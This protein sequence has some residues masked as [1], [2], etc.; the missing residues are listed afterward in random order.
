MSGLALQ[1]SLGPHW[2]MVED[3]ARPREAWPDG[4]NDEEAVHAL[5]TIMLQ[6]CEGNQDLS[7][8]HRYTLLRRGF[9]KRQDLV[10]VLPSFIRINRDLGSFW[11][12]IKARSAQ[13]APRRAHVRETFRPLYD[14]VEGITLPPVR[15]GAWTGRR[16]TPAQQAKVVLALGYDALVGV[17]MLLEDYERAHHNGGP[18]DQAEQDAINALRKLYQE[19]GLL[20]ELAERGAPLDEALREVRSASSKAMQWSKSPIGF[21]LGAL[22][23][24][25]A[26]TVLG[27]GVMYLVNAIAP[28]GVGAAIGAATIGAHVAGAGIQALRE[29]KK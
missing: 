25:G 6:G 17:E 3:R 8:G 29:T 10:D 24:T 13:W 7:L 14:R 21:A 2:R 27:V 19:L 15:S 23:L 20:I 26:S 4:M 5:E 11:A 16:R 1:Q 28:P 12:Y 22:P 9:L 18:V